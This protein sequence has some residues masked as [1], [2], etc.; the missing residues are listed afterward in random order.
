MYDEYI[1]SQVSQ[2][3]DKKRKFPSLSFND[4]LGKLQY[5]LFIILKIILVNSES[6]KRI[7]N[8]GQKL[9]PTISTILFYATRD[10][11]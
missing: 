1:Q 9:K 8:Y 5:G 10:L 11:S 2:R 6:R 7:E 3:G 4:L